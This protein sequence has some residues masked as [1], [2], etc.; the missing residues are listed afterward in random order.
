[1][2]FICHYRLLSYNNQKFKRK[3]RKIFLAPWNPN[4]NHRRRYP[5]WKPIRKY[6]RKKWRQ[7]WKKKRKQTM[8]ITK[9]MLK[10][11]GIEEWELKW[12]ENWKE[13]WKIGKKALGHNDLRPDIRIL[14]I[15][16]LYFFFGYRAMITRPAMASMIAIRTVMLFVLKNPVAGKMPSHTFS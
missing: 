15:Y 5:T 6:Q 9:T 13:K 11:E 4:R 2:N 3:N 16:H 14:G 12:N 10:K 7:E 8:K 1:M